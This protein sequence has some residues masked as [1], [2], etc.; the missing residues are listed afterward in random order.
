LEGVEGVVFMATI[1]IK[2]KPGKMVI[3]M[4]MDHGSSR[5]VEPEGEGGAPD[6]PGTRRPN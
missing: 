5:S 4:V 2:Q 6:Q 1:T 3:R